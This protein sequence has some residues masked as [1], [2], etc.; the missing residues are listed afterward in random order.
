MKKKVVLAYSGGLDTSVIL[1]WLVHEQN[2]AVVC[3]IVD[4]GQIESFEEIAVKAH[5]TGACAVHVVD[6]V[7]EFV[8]EYVLQALK[9]HAV[10]ENAYL[11]GTS[12]A[13]PLIA[14]KQIEIAQMEGAQ[15]LAHG[16]TGKGNDQARFEF[17]YASLMPCASA[18]VPWRDPTFFNRF[19][20]RSDL[21]AYASAHGIPVAAT[22]DKP[23]SIDQ[24][25]MHTS[26]ESGILED[27]TQT[28]E[29]SMFQTTVAP[30]QAPDIAAEVAITFIAG[31]PTQ[32]SNKQTGHTYENSVEILK[33]LNA[34]GGA[35]AIGRVDLVENR[36]VGLK[37]R[38]VYETPGA[39]ILFKAHGELESITLTGDVMHAKQQL[40]LQIADLIYNGLWFSRKMHMLMAA[41]QASQKHV[42][43]TIALHLYKGNMTVVSRYS[44]C[45]LYN[46]QL[47]SMDKLGGY[48]QQDAQGF[49]ALH[50]LPLKME[51]QQ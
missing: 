37:S 26:Y 27:I 7:Q 41:V 50:A 23:Y 13:R 4:V 40:G 3:A 18:I 38:G 44:P 12:L 47:V 6:A 5:A 17:A 2:Y 15:L 8:D 49:V 28:P 9:A 51:G 39:T 34:L 33:Y 35:H 21:I 31:V 48:N 25:I 22:V 43:G 10:Y 14:K 11:L 46:A 19:H 20:G 42:T 45:V 1:H 29:Q 24:N 16:A 36:L 30:E 32:V